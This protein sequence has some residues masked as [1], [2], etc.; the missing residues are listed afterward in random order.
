ME[1]RH[2]LHTLLCA[3]IV[4]CYVYVAATVLYYLHIRIDLAA[5]FLAPRSIYA[6]DMAAY[7]YARYWKRQHD[8]PLPD[9]PTLWLMPQEY[10][11]I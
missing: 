2:S 5:D 11:N 1:S 7:V 9:I 4:G 8:A 3:A 10:I 6:F